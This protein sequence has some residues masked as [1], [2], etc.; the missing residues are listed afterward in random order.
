MLRRISSAT[1]RAIYIS[2][3]AIY[4]NRTNWNIMTNIISL[5]YSLQNQQKIVLQA[6]LA[7]VNDA[8]KV[9]AKGSSFVATTR[10]PSW[11]REFGLTLG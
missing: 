9:P 1:A 6:P 5:Y 7:V 4:A 8:R 11:Q 10:C 3:E 2:I